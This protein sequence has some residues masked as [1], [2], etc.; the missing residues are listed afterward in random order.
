M[1]TSLQSRKKSDDILLPLS[2]EENKNKLASLEAKCYSE[3]LPS[4]HPHTDPLTGV[5]C[6]PTS[7]AKK[8][9]SSVFMILVDTSQT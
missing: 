1:A 7:V 5:K 9:D 2:I 3:T 8:A 4:A 6:R